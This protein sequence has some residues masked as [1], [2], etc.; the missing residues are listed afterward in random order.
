MPPRPINQLL[1]RRVIRQSL[2]FTL[3]GAINT[4]GDIVLYYILTR[5]VT[6]F[7]QHRVITKGLTFLTLGVSSFFMNRAFTFRVV[8]TAT[9][10]EYFKFL[11]T[12]VTGLLIN[13]GTTYIL[14]QRF[15]NHDIP[16]VIVAAGASYVWNFSTQ[17]LW[18]F[19]PKPVDSQS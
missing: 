18:V 5:N 10:R 4:I 11:T 3:V 12:N 13:T 6:I 17:K 16:V 19:R 14:L 15:P 7:G 9:L 2:K 1:S 8:N